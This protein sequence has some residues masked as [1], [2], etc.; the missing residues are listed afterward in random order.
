LF[1]AYS[2]PA[3]GE[4]TQKDVELDTVKEEMITPVPSS[5]Q[6]RMPDGWM[7]TDRPE[8]IYDDEDEILVEEPSQDQCSTPGV[9][10]QPVDEGEILESTCHPVKKSVPSFVEEVTR[11]DFVLDPVMEEVIM[12][13]PS[14]QQQRVPGAWMELEHPE[15]IDDDEEEEMI[16]VE[17]THEQ[18][19]SPGFHNLEPADEDEIMES[20]CPP[21]G[22]C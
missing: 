5:R 1:T 12:P 11:E 20:I 19:A 17:Q 8:M 6:P 14:S 2:I 22:L 3:F 4:T 7:E 18:F 9:P 13:V 15:M 21:R 10:L 16:A